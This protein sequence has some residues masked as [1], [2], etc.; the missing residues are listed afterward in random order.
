MLSALEKISKKDVDCVFSVSRSHQLRWA[1][2][3]GKTNPLNFDPEKRPRR[4]DW[5]GEFVEN[6]MFYFAKREL[7]LSKGVLQN[8]K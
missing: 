1:N 3:Q 5:D 4:Q 8:D 7:I 2:K 6:G